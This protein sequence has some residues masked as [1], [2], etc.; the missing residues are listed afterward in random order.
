MPSNKFPRLQRGGCVLLYGLE[1]IQAFVAN[2]FA[3]E[4]YEI[5]RVITEKT[6]GV[7]LFQDNGLFVYE[8]FN[9]VLDINAQSP[10]EF[11]RDDYPTESI[12]FSNDA[13][14]FHVVILSIS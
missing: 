12:H 10:A 5:I 4:A 8:D 13:R 6:S 11:D 3:L 9:G 14:R 7:I 2:V 1:L